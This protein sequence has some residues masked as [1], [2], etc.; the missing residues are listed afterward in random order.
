LFFAAPFSKKSCPRRLQAVSTRQFFAK[1]KQACGCEEFREN[2]KQSRCCNWIQLPK[3]PIAGKPAVKAGRRQARSQNIRPQASHSCPR[4]CGR[5]GK[6]SSQKRRMGDYEN[7][8]IAWDFF[9]SLSNQETRKLKKQIVIALALGLLSRA[10]AASFAGAVID[11]TPG[12]GVGSYNNSAAALGQPGG[13][14]S[15]GAFQGV[16]S[17]FNPHF[18]TTE[19]TG[20]GFGGQLTLQLQNYVTV[21]SGAFEIGIW[22]NVGLVDNDYPNGTAT[23]P[24]TTFSTPRGVSISVSADGTNWVS[25]NGGAPISL[26]LPG[27]F[28]TNAGPQDATA[29]ASPTFADFGKPF[30]GTLSDFNGETYAQVLATLNG[31]AGG[32]W[33][34]LDGTGL[35]QV[36]YIRFNGVASGEVEYINGVS[37]NSTLTGAAV[38][39]PATACLLI[40]GAALLLGFKRCLNS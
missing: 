18:E 10:H 4:V 26:S 28:Y 15:P 31:S 5:L 32:T 24:T 35:S 22:S 16:F 38:P 3:K 14:V 6:T 27:N 12:T 9:R 29:P 33:L 36:G 1:P 20:I 17:P 8:P 23:N 25:L 37:I 39:E 40:C 21:S 7:F 30:T 19:L 11:Y 2:R 13:I 34:D